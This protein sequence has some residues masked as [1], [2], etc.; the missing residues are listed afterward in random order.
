MVTQL[1]TLIFLFANQS[2]MYWHCRNKLEISQ[3]KCNM[4]FLRTA[5][6]FLISRQCNS[7]S[8]IYSSL[9]H[10]LKAPYLLRCKLW[11][12]TSRSCLSP[13]KISCL[14]QTSKW[15]TFQLRCYSLLSRHYRSQKLLLRHKSDVATKTSKV[16]LPK[17]SD[18]YRLLNLA[19]PEKWVLVGKCIFFK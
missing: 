1:R 6:S 19:K 17:R 15:S 3:A 2:A 18:V 12:M 14:K 7:S 5:T 13:Y 8:G 10:E 4:A 16:A 9:L 11:T